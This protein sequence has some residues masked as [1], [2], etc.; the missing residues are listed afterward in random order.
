MNVGDII[1]KDGELRIITFMENWSGEV[2][3]ETQPLKEYIAKSRI[4]QHNGD[5]KTIWEILEEGCKVALIGKKIHK[6]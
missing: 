1:E 2:T 6:A 4:V 3:T 5:Y